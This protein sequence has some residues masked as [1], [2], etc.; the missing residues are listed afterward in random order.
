MPLLVDP[1][2][3]PSEGKFSKKK[4]CEKTLPQFLY[5]D[6]ENGTYGKDFLIS[7]DNRLVEKFQ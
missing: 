4:D 3:N 6:L 7:L 2:L 5:D 1:K